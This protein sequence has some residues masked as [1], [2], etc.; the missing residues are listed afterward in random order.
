MVYQ[1]VTAEVG[2]E[3][4]SNSLGIDLA[5]LIQDSRLLEFEARVSE[6]QG[7]LPKNAPFGTF[8]NGDPLLGRFCYM[9]CRALKPRTV[10]ET[11]VCYG[12]TSS[13][14]LQ[15]LKENGSGS[16]HSID[17]PPL[18]KKGD[19][20]VGWLVPNE[21]REGWKLHRGTSRRLLRSLL[22]ELGQID[23]FV[24]DSLHTDANMKMEFAAA[25]PALRAG[26]VLISDDVEGN[27]AFLEMAQGDDV[28]FS[29]VVQ[30]GNKNAFL[31][32]AVKRE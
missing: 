9:A 16:L 12:V 18:G 25:W 4:L 27:R 6:A 19:D 5:A 14:L 28:A 22:G 11:G 23:L 3:A 32:V 30:E 21:L 1:A 17:L 29:V 13:Y 7:R 24:H 15:G 10:V 8:H 2:L 20:Y 31:G 26:G